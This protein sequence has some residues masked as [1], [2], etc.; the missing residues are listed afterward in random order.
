MFAGVFL[1]GDYDGLRLDE[2]GANVTTSV[3]YAQLVVAIVVWARLR[4][5]RPSRRPPW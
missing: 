4:R 5:V 1:S 2:A 3:G